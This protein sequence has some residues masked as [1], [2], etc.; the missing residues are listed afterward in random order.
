MSKNKQN[1]GFSARMSVFLS[2]SMCG[3][4]CVDVCVCVY[5]HTR[6]SVAG[7]PGLQPHYKS[8]KYH[9]TPLQQAGFDIKL[10]S[11]GVSMQP[12][13]QLYYTT[14]QGRKATPLPSTS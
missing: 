9:L 6:P 10:S 14:L 8:H 5:I 1:P 11:C 2:L 4:V 7:V 3:R 12:S 13:A